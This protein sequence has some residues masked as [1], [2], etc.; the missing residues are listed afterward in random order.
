MKA[1]WA[2]SGH[3]ASEVRPGHSSGQGVVK[4]PR[5]S[6][7][8]L[9]GGLSNNAIQ[10]TAC[11]VGKQVKDKAVLAPAAADGERWAGQGEWNSLCR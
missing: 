11:A 1:P 6:G 3:V 5:S 7:L 4:W 2:M 9:T 10:P 8:R